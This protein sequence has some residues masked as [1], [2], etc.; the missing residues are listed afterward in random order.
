MSEDSG[1]ARRRAAARDE[2]IPVYVQRRR[3]IVHA[4]A[5]VF[6]DKGLQGASL[7]DVAAESAADRASLYYYVGSKEEL[8]H[9]VVREAVEANLAVAEAV[10]AGE[11][12]AQ[13][14]LRTLIE[15][16]M[17]SYA[18]YFPVLYVFIQEN[19]SQV[20]QKHADWASDMRRINQRYEQILI[21]IIQQGI[22]EGTIRSFAPARE[23][24]YGVLGM[25]GWT[26][27]WFNPSTSALSAA[28]LGRVFA[29]TILGGLK[30]RRKRTPAPVRG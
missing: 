7:G 24:A 15:S 27:R 2:R 14:K 8:F 17:Q 9:E 4:A 28:E 30:A 12:D 5:R 19:L 22:D 10:I 26:H 29:D 6:K 3:E 1:I 23:L 18:E 13:H 21:E 16:L 25:L 11:G 20:P